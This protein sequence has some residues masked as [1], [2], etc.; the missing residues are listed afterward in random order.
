MNRRPGF[1][2][3]EVI[4]TLAIFALV[5]AIALRLFAATLH[6]GR[7]ISDSEKQSLAIDRAAR[8]LRRDVERST[9]PRTT[10]GSLDLGEVRWSTEPAAL[11]R[12]AGSRVDRFEPL[13]AAPSFEQDHGIV[14]LHVGDATWTLAP[15]VAK[16]SP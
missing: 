15:L 6:T 10:N 16:G 8:A 5:M 7:E 13:T 12:T 14:T 4:I 3:I 2:L 11:V 1:L 9:D